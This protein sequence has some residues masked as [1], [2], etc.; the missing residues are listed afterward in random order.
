MKPI[1]RWETKLC[2]NLRGLWFNLSACENHGE[3]KISRVTD[4]FWCC[5]W[6]TR[7]PHWAG[8]QCH[9]VVIFHQLTQSWWHQHPAP[10]VPSL[11]RLPVFFFKILHFLMLMFSLL[12][13]WA[14]NSCI[15]MITSVCNFTFL[16]PR[17]CHCS[18]WVI[19]VKLLQLCHMTAGPCFLGARAV[20][21][22]GMEAYSCGH[23][24]MKV[25]GITATC[26]RAG[27][28]MRS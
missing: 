15:S 23:R 18:F 7:N 13:P 16:P 21:P 26:D 1:S 6:R 4:A 3:K 25:Q 11:T 2:L 12:N 19:G 9:W 8:P 10:Q 27:K 22:C 28:A 14:T 17:D 24:Q 5:F 20:K